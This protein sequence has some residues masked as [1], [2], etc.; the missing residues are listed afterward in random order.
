MGEKICKKPIMRTLT[1][2]VELDDKIVQLARKQE[3]SWSA[4]ARHIIRE[5][6]NGI[7]QCQDE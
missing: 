7:A 5:Y 4:M 2:D 3:R 1:L 6:F